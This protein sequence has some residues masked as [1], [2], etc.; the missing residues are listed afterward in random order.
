M[1]I[2]CQARLGSTFLT[3]AQMNYD[4]I[5]VGGGIVGSTFACALAQQTSLSIAILEKQSSSPSWTE[6]QYY[7]RVSAISLSSQRIFQALDIWPAIKNKRVS[8][9]NQI[10]VWEALSNSQIEFNGRDIGEPTLG[11]I[12]ENNVLSNLLLLFLHSIV[13]GRRLLL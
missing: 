4:I 7:H 5:I 10:H 3:G 11:F 1:V 9:F 13:R 8:I 2:V 6:A 12:I